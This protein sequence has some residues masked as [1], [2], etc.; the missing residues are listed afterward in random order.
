[1]ILTYHW[2]IN[3]DEIVE[4]VCTVILPLLNGF[5]RAVQSSHFPW[6]C[7]DFESV[8]H[9]TQPLV[10]ND[11]LQEVGQIIETLTQSLEPQHYYAKKFLSRYQHRGSPLSSNGIILDITTMMRNMLARAI[12]AS[13]HNDD[14]VTLMT[15]KEIWEVLVKSKANIIISVTDYVR[16]AL[17]K[18]YIMSLQ[19][20]TELTGLLDNLVAQGN[21]HPSSLYVR[22]IMA[23]SLDLAAI[24]SIYLHE[25]DDELISK[26]TASLFNVPQTPDVK[27]QKSA[28]DA[29]TLLALKF[30]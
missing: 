11:C 14:S 5:F 3:F 24:A 17:H 30:V 19:Y 10:N 7:N 8:A 22:E 4:Y 1:L 26:L 2:P 20:F 16:K 9:Q 28:L 21:D 6:H 12:I 25:V 13:N 15:F 29:T 27:V 18:T 23:T